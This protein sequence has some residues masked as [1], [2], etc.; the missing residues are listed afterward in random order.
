[1]QRF[2]FTV[3]LT[4]MMLLASGASLLAQSRGG[5]GSKPPKPQ[6]STA[7]VSGGPKVS[8]SPKVTGGPKVSQPPKVTG[9]AKTTKPSTTHASGGPKTTTTKAAK[10]PVAKAGGAKAGGATAGGAKAN[11]S[12]ATAVPLTA[13]QLKV[14]K[15]TNLASK[16]QSRLPAG[17]DL[18][19]AAA[20]FRNL[21]QF[22]AAVNVSNNLGIDFVKLKAKMVDDGF[23]LGQSIQALKP[24]ASGTVE[25][26]RAEYEA[27]GMILDAEGTQ[28]TASAT[29]T[30]TKAKKT[31][32]KT[33]GGLDE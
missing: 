33:G 10:D 30:T 23:S 21:G 2:K 5:G 29:V 25:A 16:L 15:N 3:A 8:Q 31:G 32:A 18:M 14:Q 20:D 7:K 24:T 1:M 17:T 27:R 11:T 22:V 26:Q 9:G 19:K 6:A 4:A 13:V 12:S 28:V